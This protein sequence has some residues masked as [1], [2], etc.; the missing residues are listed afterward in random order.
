M[1]GGDWGGNFEF[2][3]GLCDGEGIHGDGENR[4]GFWLF[5]FGLKLDLMIY[6]AVVGIGAVTS[7]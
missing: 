5:C 4:F 1:V 7:P 2:G 3:F 6:E